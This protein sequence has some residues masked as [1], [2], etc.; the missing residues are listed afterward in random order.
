MSY[1][2]YDIVMYAM[3][4]LWLK[5]DEEIHMLK[6]FIAIC[7]VLALLAGCAQHAT[8]NAQTALTDVAVVKEDIFLCNKAPLYVGETAHHQLRLQYKDKDYL[9][10]QSTEDASRYDNK[11]TQT[12]FVRDQLFA[13]LHL[14]KTEVQC[15]QKANLNPMKAA[16]NEPNW[17]LELQG[18]TV[19]FQQNDQPAVQKRISTKHLN[20]VALDRQYTTFDQSMTIA[21][22]SKLC[23]DSMSGMTYPMTARVVLPNK[24]LKGCAGDPQ[25]VIAGTWYVDQID[26]QTVTV[27]SPVPTMT[28]NNGALYGDSGC[29]RYRAGYDLTGEGMTIKP[30][31]STR[32]M[33]APEQ[34]KVESLFLKHMQSVI[35][36]EIAQDGSLILYTDDDKKMH[37]VRR[38]VTG[39]VS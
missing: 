15:Q 8:K 31:I 25:M 16:G 32:M 4:H 17:S 29:N 11:E 37:A 28:W 7:S 33:C 18:D 21:L 10:T 19:T 26:G 1:K 36:F 38:L 39:K 3:T 12:M 22:S 20:V 5:E 14:G 23:E 13:A 30:I 35:R 6:I 24:T 9:L 27:D 34:N 2:V